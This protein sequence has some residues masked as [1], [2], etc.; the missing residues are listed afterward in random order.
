MISERFSVI[1]TKALP[2]ATWP[3]QFLRTIL[4]TARTSSLPKGRLL[5]LS[6]P[7]KRLPHLS[8]LTRIVFRPALETVGGGWGRGGRGI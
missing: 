4:I 2:G 6:I 7:V 5:P 8:F 1:E 3:L